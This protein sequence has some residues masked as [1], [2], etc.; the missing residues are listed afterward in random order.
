[1]AYALYS[2]TTGFRNVASGYRALYTNTSGYYNT[3]SGYEALGSNTSGYSNT[4]SG[5]YS[6]WG[7]TIGKFNT[8]DGYYS[9]SSNSSGDGNTAVGY[10][11][12]D[13]NTSGEYNTAM[14]A[15][16]LRDNSTGDFNT[17]IG[18]NALHSNRSGINGTAIGAFAMNNAYDGSSFTNYNVAVG[19]QAMYGS[20]TASNNSGNYNA[21]LGYQALMSYTSGGNNTAVGY[22]AGDINT[23][24]SSNT[25]IGYNSDATSGQLSNST[26]IGANAVVAKSNSLV[27]GDT[28]NVNVGIGTGSPTAKLDVRGTIKIVDG[29]Q[30]AGKVLTSDANGLASWVTVAAG[31]TDWTTTGNAGTTNGTNFIGTTDAQDLDFRTNNVIRTRITQKGQIEV[32]NTG[33]SVFLGEQAGENDDLTNNVN[34]F[35]GYQAGFS[36]TI[37]A[38]NTA[39]GY[40][41]LYSNTTGISN[42]VNGVTA[43]YNN[44]TGS[45]NTASGYQSLFFNTT[46]HNNTAKGYVALRN[47][48]TA[49]YNTAIGINALYSQSYDNGGTAWSS[50]NTAIGSQALYS[51]QPTTTT[52]GYRNTALGN[53]AGYSNT[54]GSSNTF[55]GYNADASANNLTN[56]TAIGANASVTAS[57]TVKLGS[58]ANVE[59]D[60][61]L[62][63]NNLPGTSGQVLTSQGTGASPTWTSLPA[64]DGNGI[65]D[66]TGSLTSSTTVFLGAN[67][68]DFNAGVIDA[69]SVDGTTFSVDAQNNAVGIGDATPD[70]KLEVRQTTTG[71]IFNLYDNTT[72]VFTVLDGGNVGIG[73]T[74]PTYQLDIRG[75]GI[76]SQT[77]IRALD[78]GGIG[79]F[80]LESDASGDAF[81]QL[82]QTAGG[83]RVQLHASD[84]SYFT[85]GNVG[86]GT[87]TPD[88]LLDVEGGGIYISEIAAPATPNTG[89]GVLYEKT[90]GKLYFKNDGGS[91]LDLTQGGGTGGW[92]DGGTDVYLTTSTD[93]VG[94]GTSSP[95][96]PL[97][98]SEATNDLLKIQST[99]GGG[100]NTAGILFTTFN[101][102]S[103]ANAK[104][105]AIDAGTFNGDLAFYTDGDGV[106][107]SNVLERMRITSTGYVGI[108]VTPSSQLHIAGG[109]GLG[110]LQIQNTTTDEAHVHL[111]TPSGSSYL[112][113]AGAAAEGWSGSAAGDLVLSNRTGGA[114]TLSADAGFAEAHLHITE[115]GNV[116]INQSTPLYKL[117]VEGSV[118]GTHASYFNAAGGSG[119]SGVK[120]N[121]ING[122]T[123]GY[124][125]VQGA[126]DFDGVTTADWSG[127]EIGIVGISTG[128]SANDNFGVVGHSNYWGMRAEHST[129]GNSVNLGGTTYAMQIVDG[130]QAA[131]FVLSS[132]ASGNATWADPN[133]LSGGNWT[134]DGNYVYNATDSIGIGTNAP[135]NPLTV[136]G[137]ADFINNVGIGVVTADGRLQVQAAGTQDILNLSNDSLPLI[138]VR[139][140]GDMGIGDNIASPDG[141]LEVRQN[142]T[143]DIFN[144]YDGATNV[145]SVL[146]GG[147]LMVDAATTFYVDA[148]SDRVGIGAAIP[149]YKLHVTGGDA[150]TA[151]AYF[152]SGSSNGGHAVQGNGINGPTR[153]YLGAQGNTGFDGITTANWSGQ[154]IGV[155][156]IS[157]GSSA[158]DNF[159]VL[160]HSNYW[161]MRAEHSTSGNSVNLGGTTYAMQI[162]D[163]NQ[164]AGYVLSSDAS[165]NA[166]WVDPSTV[167]DGDWTVS[168][169]SMSSSVSGNVGIGT[170][171]PGSKLDVTG[172]VNILSATAHPLVIRASTSGY[173]TLIKESDDGFDAIGLFG[174]PSRGRIFINS[175][176]TTTIELDGSGVSYFNGG[177]VGINESSPGVG[178]HLTGKSIYLDEDSGSDWG[179]IW[180]KAQNQ[181]TSGT[182][183]MFMMGDKNTSR[184]E[185]ISFYHVNGSPT[186]VPS[187]TY[188]TKAF[189]FQWN[190][191]AYGSSWNTTGIDLAEKFPSSE[192]GLEPGDVVVL[193][194]EFRER[195]KGSCNGYEETLLGV[196][197]ENPGVIL[198]GNNKELE[199]IDAPPVALTG[200][201]PVKVTLEGGPIKIGDVLTSSS[202]PKHGMKASKTGAVFGIALEPFNGENGKAGKILCYINVHSWVNPIEFKTLQHLLAK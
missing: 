118:T 199:E 93:Q 66:G 5:Y 42:T 78:G 100:G 96:H 69:F 162:V 101:T 95:L 29:S 58:S 180:F 75:T 192:E 159:G 102:G 140:D 186:N 185:G 30:G 1:G 63:P 34:V 9:L 67:K 79:Q 196:I 19:Y 32:L 167:D 163:G 73:Q 157:T 182:H 104:I 3:A 123:A 114:I 161:G 121:G 134:K 132:D 165:G 193:D 153:G 190:G 130:N 117:H 189:R 64:A 120:G 142:T 18:R 72:N 141:K 146:D 178:L 7:N 160:G 191:A 35:V 176:G 52:T 149:S 112:V 128:G 26:A 172:N 61:D 144:L 184:D 24:G 122:P 80:K 88:G 183:Q 164:A 20:L 197:S 119:S 175:G 43:L 46:G 169:S 16:S 87:T 109:S 111:Q 106:N 188:G 86:I 187:D 137:N 81:M 148:S 84:V 133:T 103:S 97:H 151:T 37:G 47:N 10:N 135:S 2:S 127:Q 23:S 82:S 77:Y 171:S 76:V 166:S 83:T 22:A 92:T 68:L 177:N 201:V 156:G 200:R 168:G 125:G 138:T 173:G 129:S 181:G 17:A 31:S 155:V 158:T 38:N 51:N 115:A 108:G 154:E 126:T 139:S 94:I 131:G 124:L 150:G 74:N 45:Q 195:I 174:Y 13:G 152:N 62:R 4:A 55:I 33:L 143:D 136:N 53:F 11:A 105:A 44:T 90:D 39:S 25:F 65:Y 116:G 60:G 21:A 107:N 110:R 59:F 57:N 179:A 54:T 36:N 147:D 98:I 170:A 71:D 27:L 56:A 15:Y 99:I 48:T 91:E 145:L 40:R 198:G 8:A 194:L 202:T 12:L 28:T 113:G 6:L 89:K 41:A 85:G 70:G 50:F 49:S 14:G